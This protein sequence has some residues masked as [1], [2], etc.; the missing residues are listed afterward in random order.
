M[1]MKN[2]FILSVATLGIGLALVGG[3]TFAYFSDTEEVNNS[4]AAGTLDLTVNPTVV[5]DVHNL[6][7]GD[8]MV[9]DFDITNS[10]TIDI[11]DVLMHTNYSV[12]DGNGDNGNAD[13]GKHIFIEF[14]TSDGDLILL[15]KSLADMRKLTQQGKSPDI[16]NL[17]LKLK[18]LP[19]GDSDRIVMKINFVDNGLDQNIFQEDTLK[20]TWTL[21]AK[22]GAGK[23]L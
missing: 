13:F 12:I 1:N 9:R 16:S 8:F 7:P 21:E 23:K 11:E 22:Q 17:Y 14:L 19:V 2:K 20:L 3:G 5:F 6:K 18:N 10:G 4:F 15:N